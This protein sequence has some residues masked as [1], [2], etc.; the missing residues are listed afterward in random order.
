MGFFSWL[1]G[2][3]LACSRCGKRGIPF[4]QGSGPAK[5]VIVTS[6]EQMYKIIAK[7]V[8]CGK[9]FCGK[10]A[11]KTYGDSSLMACPECGAQVGPCDRYGTM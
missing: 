6:K 4:N 8:G 10:C 7:C 5:V 11:E 3:G 1:F 2:S 9:L